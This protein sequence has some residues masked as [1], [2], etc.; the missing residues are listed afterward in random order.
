MQPF[1]NEPNVQHVTDWQKQVL[2]CLLTFKVKFCPFY[3]YRIEFLLVQSSKE[4]KQNVILN[5]HNK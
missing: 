3:P 2:K 5:N 1:K 4:T